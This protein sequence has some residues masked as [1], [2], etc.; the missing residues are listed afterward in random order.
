MT[1]IRQ[2]WLVPVLLLAGSLVACGSSQPPPE[3]EP[4][5]E[6]HQAL[7]R[8]IQEPLDRA[9]AVEDTLQKQ[10]E[11]LQRQLDEDGG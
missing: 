10:Q 1:P 5:R 3:P 4:P 11:S 6:E 8:A 9:R 2:L 7:Q